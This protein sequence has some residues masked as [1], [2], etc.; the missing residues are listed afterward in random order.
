M[1]DDRIKHV[2]VI[3]PILDSELIHDTYSVLSKQLQFKR[4]VVKSVSEMLL[5]SSKC[6]QVD[7]IWL[8]IEV[9][10]NLRTDT[11]KSFKDIISGMLFALECN[12]GCVPV[13]GVQFNNPEYIPQVKEILEHPSVI[14]L[15]THKDFFENNQRH[16]C[17]Q[18]LLSRHCF[19]GVY[20]EQLLTVGEQAK[21]SF[22][23]KIVGVSPS[24]PTLLVENI[25]EKLK[26]YENTVV[27]KLDSLH[28]MCST[29]LNEPELPECICI[30]LDLLVSVEGSSLIDVVNMIVT[31][32]N[33]NKSKSYK[34]HAP[35]IYVN[36]RPHSDLDQI[37]AVLRLPQVSG[38][39]CTTDFSWPE[40]QA[41]V[42]DIKQ[43]I[44]HV[45]EKIKQRL[46]TH[47]CATVGAKS[48]LNQI[49]LTVREQ[50]IMEIICSKG[51]SNKMIANQLKITESAVKLHIGN[52]LKKHRVKN[53]TE[54][55]IKV[56]QQVLTDP[57]LLQ[58]G[59]C[60]PDNTMLKC[61]YHL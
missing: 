5:L 42:Q 2:I 38:L 44:Y 26:V 50:Q 31:M 14:C 15:M 8:D 30:D 25:I 4:T 28:D 6:E 36:V 32:A 17:Y 27:V 24:S 55:A 40:I 61:E 21:D 48:T 9:L 16:T 23:F 1:S 51:H 22:P 59:V 47:K 57:I 54:L 43:R 56:G 19:V 18:A 52:I 45:P 49:T 13:I 7:A 3:K 35:S 46:D 39:S 11:K 53:R 58:E 41:C 29:L 37:R 60:A 12:T 34:S 20:V 10:L 33:L